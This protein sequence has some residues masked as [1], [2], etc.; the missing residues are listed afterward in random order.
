M[1][2]HR[3]RIAPEG[4]GTGVATATADAPAGSPARTNGVAVAPDTPV[5]HDAPRDPPAQPQ[6]AAASPAPRPAVVHHDVVAHVEVIC[7]G[8]TNVKVP[9]A[10]CPRY[11]GMALA[12]PAKEFDRQI[13]SWLTR[14]VDLGMIG[15]D[16]GQLFPVNLQ[17]SQKDGRVKV[18]SLLM[19]G[20]G[21]PGQFAA[22]D[23]RYLMSNV[24]VAVK[25]MGHDHLST[26]LIGTRRNELSFG[27]AVRGLLEG[28]LDGYER[29]RVIADAVTYHR[30]DLMA[31]AE[32]DLFVSL[33]EGD[34]ER[35]RDIFAAFEAIGGDRSIPGLRMELSRGDDVDPDPQAD[36]RTN[37]VEPYVPLTLLRITRGATVPMASPA[38]PI[39]LVG[40]SGTQLFEFSGISDVAAVTVRDVEV[41]SY[42]VRE[43][44]E[45]M[46]NAASPDDQEA[47]GTFFSNCLI[48]D[49]FR[50]LAEGSSDITLEVDET[51]ASFPWEMSAHKK[52]SKT[53]FMGTS[54]CVSRQ[55]RTLYA[56]APGSP[57]A[58]NRVHKVLIIADPAPGRLSL[59]HAREEGRVVVDVIDHART[60]WAGEYDFRVTV[61][62]G[63]DQDADQSRKECEELRR[64]G[65][66][67]VSA[68]PCDPLKLALLIVNEQFDVIHYAGHGAFDRKS[69]RAGWV[70]DEDC[71]LSA[72]EIF[73]VRQVPRLVF[74][75]ACFSA[76]ATSGS[77]QRGHL[78][79]LA[80]AFFARGIPNFIGA[81]WK[82]DDVCARECARWFYTRV[83]G[84]RHPSQSDDVIGTSPP[85]TIG[86]SLLEARRAAFEVKKDSSSW[87]AYQHYG[88]TT[89]KLL[90]LPNTRRSRRAN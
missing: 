53:R 81:G 4:N 13:D 60:A 66:W 12:G 11:K 55:F 59:P 89:D 85:A 25:S 83:W 47:F 9:I 88:R 20:M 39:A 36:P 70:F 31:A 45:R 26:M 82:V 75:N 74:A 35:A 30:E 8:Y 76:V 68:E 73:R 10:V 87:G 21:P 69:G 2:K 24:T 72:Q 78:V 44:P 62:L 61:R 14:A 34:P 33:V 28:I 1:A 43:L 77:E 41:N 50:L 48:P 67:I 86:E 54:V 90:P 6:A 16:L 57:P 27:Q 49:D 22:D 23:L 38:P 51:T 64:R 18:D 58:L 79:G 65:D 42:I 19:V 15:S 63:C 84:L 29:F 56:P 17:R 80:Q 46:T 52:Y 37:D 71:F 7:G 32:R 3:A 40:T 5:A